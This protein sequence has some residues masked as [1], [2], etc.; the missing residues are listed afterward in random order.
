MFKTY[1]KPVLEA[2]SG[3]K[4]DYVPVWFMRQA[5]RTL[6]EYRAI[7]EKMQ[8]YDMFQTP[9]VAAEVTLQPLKRYPL[10]AAIVYAD[11]LHIPDVL[12]LGLKFVKGD[13]PVFDRPIHV[14]ADVAKLPRVENQEQKQEIMSKLSF[15]TETLKLVKPELSPTQ[16]LIGFAGAPWTVVSY[17]VEGGGSKTFLKTKTFMLQ[18]PESFKDMMQV[19]T[20]WT[21]LYLKSQV[22]AGAEALQ[23]FESWGGTALTPWQYSEFAAP[24]SEQILS[25]IDGVAKVHFV[26]KSAG[27]LSEV[28]QGVRSDV[29]G[30]DWN[31][32][33]S[34]VLQHPMLGKRAIQGNLDP[35]CFFQPWDVLKASIDRVLTEAKNNQNGFV[36]NVG[37]GLP[38]T[39]PIDS[40]L[41]TVEYLKAVSL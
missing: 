30:V 23:L 20:D 25:A 40:I 39:T 29:L 27:L 35:A 1:G 33:L 31:Q 28:L 11:I 6:P 2:F 26:N 17:M 5:G 3:K 41:K 10:D 8:T 38:P 7:K 36:F 19:V 15:I 16:T 18:H 34:N 22:E 13:G 24:Y 32:S 21:I 12:G 37:H 14:P 9:D 4:T